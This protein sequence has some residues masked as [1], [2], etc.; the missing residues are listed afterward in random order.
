MLP[1]TLTFAYVDSEFSNIDAIRPQ[2]CKGRNDE[3]EMNYRNV[4]KYYLFSLRIKDIYLSIHW[5]ETSF[6]VNIY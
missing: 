5:N 2:K 6:F 4:L 1:Y 3:K